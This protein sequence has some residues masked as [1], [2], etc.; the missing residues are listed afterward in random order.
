MR[1]LTALVGLSLLGG[2]ALTPTTNAYAQDYDDLDSDTARKKR[3]KDRKSARDRLKNDVVREINRGFFVR[4]NIGGAFYLLTYGSQNLDRSILSGGTTVALTVGNDFID[5]ERSSMAYELQVY[6]GVHNGMN[7]IDQGYYLSAGAMSPDR[8]IQGD[9]RTLA[10]ML[11]LEYSIYPSRRLGIGLRVTGG[12]L[13]APM[14]MN[15]Q[16]AAYQDDVLDEWQANPTVHDTI[17]PMFGGGPTV[18]YYTKLSHFS[19]GADVDVTYSIGFDLGVAA[20]GYLKY[21][22]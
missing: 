2:V 22:F 20:S 18:E 3:N 9:T 7:Y 6:S 11:G 21:T 5:Q 12:V 4:A 1:T 19:L 15:T 10:A 17:H 14:L 16:S 13:Y 8:I